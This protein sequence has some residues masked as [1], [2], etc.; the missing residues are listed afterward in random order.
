MTQP[1]MVRAGNY[2]LTWR[3]AFGNYR[4]GVYQPYLI[5]CSIPSEYQHLSVAAVSLVENECDHAKNALTVFYNK[6][7][8][9]KQNFA[10]CVKN[11][12]FL[13]EDVSSVLTE[14]I[15]MMTLLGA[16]KIFLYYLNVHP[17]I[18]KVF[19]YYED[20]GRVEAKSVMNRVQDEVISLND[21]L[22]KHM[23]EYKYLVVVDIDEVIVPLNG[24]TWNDLM[25]HLERTLD[26]EYD[27]YNAR[28]VYYFTDLLFTHKW[29]DDVPEYMHI[30]NHIHRAPTILKA[31]I[32]IK[33]FHNT[34][35]VLS[36][37]NHFP[38]AC[39]RG[40]CKNFPINPDDALMHHYKRKPIKRYTNFRETSI[41]DTTI[42]KY[43]KVLVKKV[44][45]ALKDMGFLVPLKKPLRV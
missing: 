10:V 43:K 14:W 8:G 9:E 15:E 1:V 42:W 40:G 34:K 16:D 7:R 35:T 31:G 5:P 25:D 39:L 21:C 41:I 30:L 27:S 29:F 12:D 17:N 45:K 24:S 37:H 20:L 38:V 18:S 28:N 23:H 26:K 3:K 11:L 6:P 4:K 22:Y 36:L 2:S 44:T 19:K 32:N 33:S 13:L